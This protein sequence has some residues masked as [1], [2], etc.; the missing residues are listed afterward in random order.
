MKKHS[1]WKILFISFITILSCDSSNEPQNENIQDFEFV[2]ETIENYYPFIEFKQINLDSI[3]EQ[4]LPLFENATKTEMKTILINFLAELKDGHA[5]VYEGKIPVYGYQIPR[6][7]KDKESFDIKTVRSYFNKDF[8]RFGD[9]F[10][11]EIL[12]D[13][14]GYIYYS[15]FSENPMEYE[16]FDL[17]LDYLKNTNG[18]I[19]DIRHNQGGNNS[20]GRYFIKRLISSSLES[21]QWTKKGGGFYP[22]ETYEPEGEYQYIKPIV[23]LV[24]GV[25]FSSSEGFANLCKKASHITVIGDTTG[26]GSG[27]PEIFTLN[28]SNVKLRIPIRCEMRYD[29]KHYEWNGIIPD[30]IVSQT[31][32]DI[33]L[34]KDKQLERAIEFLKNQ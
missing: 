25:S 14:I 5:N 22:I 31:K 13:N 21:T 4:Y 9:L 24:N 34:N 27:V 20:S 30:I 3:Y 26:G 33:E 8:K 16:K 6:Y 2:Y 11:Y 28:N 23:L 12:P 10:K 19:M 18:L 1:L 15:E 7:E 17:I 32:E 29:G